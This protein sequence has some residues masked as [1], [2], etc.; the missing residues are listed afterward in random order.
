M[1]RHR[2]RRGEERVA[3]ERVLVAAVFVFD[4][5]ERSPGASLEVDAEDALAQDVPEH[6]RVR[7]RPVRHL[8]LPR[9]DAEVV[10][11]RLELE[12]ADDVLVQ[13]FSRE[14]ERVH[15]PPIV[16]ELPPDP[17]VLR[18]QKSRVELPRVVRREEDARA[19]R[20]PPRLLDER[21]EELGGA[22]E[23][24]HG[25]AETALLVMPVSATIGGGMRNRPG[26]TS[27]D[28]GACVG[29]FTFTA[30]ISMIRFRSLLSP[31]VSRSN[32]ITT[33]ISAAAAR[34]R[35]TPGGSAPR[36]PSA[37]LGT[38][39]PRLRRPP[40]AAR[41]VGGRE[42]GSALHGA[43]R[44]LASGAGGA[45]GSGARE[46]TT[47]SAPPRARRRS[48]GSG[49]ASTRAA[50]GARLG[51]RAA[52]RRTTPRRRGCSRAR[53]RVLPGASP[54]RARRG[55]RTGTAGSR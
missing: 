39:F 26:F 40:R 34:A 13:H 7:L 35:G 31:V 29:S 36:R 14:R 2:R 55:G 50:S 21:L 8:A 6:P 27:V 38:P 12:R 18:L 51:P 1:R 15:E 17:T 10:R 32:T 16:R 49:T 24:R 37:P 54:P 11:E 23:R 46:A 44:A 20:P 33:G 3:P 47:V 28:T 22:R 53:R 52:S 48:A 9:A 19:P 41:V 30:A 42:R 5:R 45:A 4:A 25:G 43:V